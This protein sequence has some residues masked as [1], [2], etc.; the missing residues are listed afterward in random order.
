MSGGRWAF[1]RSI[2][3]FIRAHTQKQTWHKQVCLCI[4]LAVHLARHKQHTTLAVRP[5]SARICQ[6]RSPLERYASFRALVTK[7][8]HILLSLTTAAHI[9]V[10]MYL[11]YLLKN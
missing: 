6:C 4:F 5:L 9:S 8:D 7:A 1:A 11:F 3:C 10:Q 2:R